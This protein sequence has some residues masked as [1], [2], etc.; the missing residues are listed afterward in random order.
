MSGIE[1]AGLAL[2]VLPILI[3]I[4]KQARSKHHAASRAGVMEDLCWEI[5]QLNIN[6][7]GLVKQ[8]PS[9][10]HDELLSST[11]PQQIERAWKKDNISQLLEVRLRHKY[12]SFSMAL[13]NILSCLDRLIDKESLKLSDDEVTLPGPAYAKLRAI[14]AHTTSATTPTPDLGSRIRFAIYE[15]G[16]YIKDLD[17]ITVNNERLEKIISSLQNVSP[18]SLDIPG[19]RKQICTPHLNLRPVMTT[20]YAS[21]GNLWPC[22]CHERHTACLSLVKRCDNGIIASDLASENV[23]FRMLISLNKRIEGSYWKL[24]ESQVWVMLSSSS[25]LP[26]LPAAR[27][28]VQAPNLPAARVNILPPSPT[29]V[30]PPKSALKLFKNSYHKAT[31]LVFGQKKAI[32]TTSVEKSVR[33]QLQVPEVLQPKGMPSTGPKQIPLRK[34]KRIDKKLCQSLL[35]IHNSGCRPELLYDGS[36]LRRTN[37]LSKSLDQHKGPYLRSDVT[38]SSLAKFLGEAKRMKLKERQ[39]LAVILAHSLLHLCESPWLGG[40]WSKDQ[41][42]FLSKSGAIDT[43]RPY[44]STDFPTAQPGNPSAPKKDDD[45]D[46]RIHPNASVLALGILLLEI[47]LQQP[48]EARRQADDLDTD[49]QTTVNTDYFTALQALDD[50]SDEIPQGYREIISECFKCSFYDETTMSPSLDDLDFRQGVYD[51]IVKPLEIFLLVSFPEVTMNKIGVEC[52]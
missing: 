39:I 5:T 36:D 26:T 33:V 24:L 14:K 25:Q 42:M 8:L 31:N 12:H 30:K 44:I 32:I 27:V 50:A 22:D 19:N 16:R 1:I 38:S 37:R 2:A 35:Q 40:D 43:Q 7:E 47:A 10:M 51:Y 45:D 23:S 41:I 18:L 21:M 52:G 46:F 34:E 6:L 11:S 9:S 49:G 20:L 48:I 13:E 17:E 3:E 4:A 29:S 15:Q 28:D